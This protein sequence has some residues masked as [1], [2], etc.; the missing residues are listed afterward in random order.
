MVGED[1]R[2]ADSK[3]RHGAVDRARHIHEAVVV[4][5]PLVDSKDSST[6][7]AGE[8]NVHMGKALEQD[9]DE[10]EEVPTSASCL[11]LNS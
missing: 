3:G 2:L 9:D 10:Q 4:P 11:K 6:D 1:S 5:L 7:N 8:D